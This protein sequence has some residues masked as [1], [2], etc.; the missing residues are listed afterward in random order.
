MKI[1]YHA[2]LFWIG[3]AGTIAS[4]VASQFGADTHVA[5]IASGLVA[6]LAKTERGIQA[7]EDSQPSGPP[8]PPA[9]TPPKATP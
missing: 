4:A 5:M 1:D 7:F 3:I 6:L 9:P 2:I 8:A